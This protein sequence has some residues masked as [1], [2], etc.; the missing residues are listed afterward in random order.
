ML[1]Y[2]MLDL[3]SL[4]TGIPVTNAWTDGDS[5]YNAQAQLVPKIAIPK[6]ESTDRHS[7]DANFRT[8]VERV[9][10]N[11]LTPVRVPVD[12]AITINNNP[13]KNT[14]RY[15]MYR[16]M[17]QAGERLPPIIVKPHGK[18]ARDENMYFVVDG[19]HRWF[20]ALAEG[21]QELDALLVG[22]SLAAFGGLWRR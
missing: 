21:A 16:R 10:G 6:G 7:W 13:V 8:A 1:A 4:A 11:K 5:V 14:A 22:E 9:F 15:Q 3:G 2:P 19:N 18:N 17:L 20:A 12:P